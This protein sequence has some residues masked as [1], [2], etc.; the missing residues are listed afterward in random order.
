[1]SFLETISIGMQFGGIIAL[2]KLSFEVKQGEITG[3]I[4]P[5][6]AGK[7]TFFNV[8]TGFIKPTSGK[9]L[10]K[11]EDITRLKSYEIAQKGIFRSFQL[12]SLFPTLTVI[13]NIITGFHLINKSKW[14]GSLFVTKNH[15]NQERQN[16][17]R[18]IELLDF[19]DMRHLSDYVAGNLPYGEQRKLEI[20]IALAGNP[21][22]LLLDEPVAGMVEEESR[23]IMEIIKTLQNKGM[24]ILIVEHDMK[25]I[26][27]IC[28]RI[29]V[30]NFG[31]KIAEGPPEQIRENEDVLRVYL[32][33]KKS[34]AFN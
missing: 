32:G 24:T 12:T 4:G 31:E 17:M 10:F 22:L 26:M 19:L 1:M 30:L 8:L 23:K 16:R 27:G 28:Q 14:L 3:I 7:T 9:I 20:A 6:G 34:Y 18:A 21:E 33:K 25:F 29:I 11:K 5:N 2:D 13:E 15:K